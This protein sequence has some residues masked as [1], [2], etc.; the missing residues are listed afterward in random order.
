[1]RRLFL[2]MGMM[3][4]LGAAQSQIKMHS[5]VPSFSF[6]GMKTFD[7]KLFYLVYYGQPL[8]DIPYNY[9]I[10]MYDKDLNRLNS[11]VIPV[12]YLGSVESIIEHKG[13]LM[14]FV[15]SGKEGKLI[16]YNSMGKKEFTKDFLMEKSDYNTVG[17]VSLGESGFAITRPDKEKKDGFRITVYNPVGEEL[18]TKSYFPEKGS[19]DWKGIQSAGDYLMVHTQY[20]KSA[21]S[22]VYEDKLYLFNAK[23]GALLSEQLVTT[24]VEGGLVKQVKLN[25]DGSTFSVGSLI[26]KNQ[27]QKLET[28]AVF[29]RSFDV[30]GKLLFEGK[31]AY[32]DLMARGFV[33]DL[34]KKQIALPTHLKY[35]LVRQKEYGYEIIAEQYVWDQLPAPPAQPGAPPALASPGFVYILDY[36]VFNIGKDGKLLD[37]KMIGKP[38][39]M[40]QLDGFNVSDAVKADDLFTSLNLFAFSHVTS[41]TNELVEL[42]WSN[43]VPYVGFN[44]IVEGH[45][46]VLN[47]LYLSKVITDRPLRSDMSSLYVKK[48]GLEIPKLFYTSGL[49]PFEGS[50]KALYYEMVS[51]KGLLLKVMDLKA[52]LPVVMD[53]Q[54]IVSGIGVNDLVT[55]NPIDN[56]GYFLFYK[57]EPAENGVF[58]YI[59][60][61]LDL[62]LNTVNRTILKIPTDA[63]YV[64]DLQVKDGHILAFK[65]G[66]KH[67]WV[68]TLLDKSG[69]AVDQ[70]IQPD[71]PGKDIYESGFAVLGTAPDGFYA[72]TPIYIPNLNAHGYR[73]TRFNDLRKLQWT[74]NYMAGKSE[75]IELIG[76]DVNSGVF[77]LIHS[78]RPKVYSNQ[79][80]NEVILI[81]D[82]TGTLIS[83]TNLFDGED[84]PFPQAIRV[85]GGDVIC[86]GMFFKGSKFDNK[87]SDGFFYLRL[88]S[89]GQKTA[90]TKSL[91]K[92]AETLLKVEAGSD[93]LVSGKVQVFIQ[94]ML[95][96][97]AG[98]CK[99]VGELYKK[100][101]GTTGVGFLMGDDTGDRAFSVYDFIIFD[102][103]ANKLNSIYRIPKTEQ[104][105]L[106]EGSTGHI[107]GLS[108]SYLMKQYRVF[109]YLKSIRNQTSDLLVYKN[110]VSGAE[111]VYASTVSA[112]M[113]GTIK[114]NVQPPVI[115]QPEQEIPGAL[116]NLSAKMDEINQKLQ[117]AGN[118]LQFAMT[119]TDQV[120][121][122]SFDPSK[123]YLVAS[124]N[125]ALVYYFNPFTG[126]LHFEKRNLQ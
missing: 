14:V 58:L 12:K 83:E 24:D 84:T 77:A 111:Y 75:S 2:F 98:N 73:I 68:F 3:L 124:G 103:Q 114:S 101:V 37:M 50:S 42:N 33:S 92:D 106:V 115:K 22:T 17:M 117:N 56:Q 52:E 85:A 74:G 54:A 93:F 35:H 57:A 27:Q 25:A 105:V 86:S 64:G 99:L 113:P 47:R 76:S 32:A 39:K 125:S 121:S 15:K 95:V 19:I 70:N 66:N 38:H 45:E 110:V 122:Y 100:S 28:T 55:L 48:E 69:K 94:D 67:Q 107:Q 18:W 112:T 26:A 1:M 6:E 102:Y 53:N 119:G 60:H 30:S 120:L 10:Q 71:E 82:K 79:I 51:G 13:G 11:E 9:V 123:G 97:A 108:L 34:V 72:T 116:G 62:N 89:K 61:Q 65:D 36:A 7:G 63:R 88:S 23:D 78:K 21:F 20:T 109:S 87:N 4:L 16:A 5:D 43:N 31:L 46:S 80:V 49:L 44:S 118:K 40:L 81:D 59:Y 41:A 96:D 29:Y 104:N 91:W 126:K 8:K 90:Y